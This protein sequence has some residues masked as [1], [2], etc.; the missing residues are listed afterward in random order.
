MWV[1]AKRL[2]FI[3]FSAKNVESL[4]QEGKVLRRMGTVV[5]LV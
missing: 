4:E 1:R 2:A 5:E 3:F